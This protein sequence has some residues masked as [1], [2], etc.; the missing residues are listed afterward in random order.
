[1]Q[2]WQGRE[3]EVLTCLGGSARTDYVV[4]YGRDGRVEICIPDADEGE[5][6]EDALAWAAQRR[7]RKH[8]ES[9]KR[10]T[11]RKKSE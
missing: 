2:L 6:L 1:M 10:L 5:T 8:R 11:A 4:V 3:G 7:D 9:Q